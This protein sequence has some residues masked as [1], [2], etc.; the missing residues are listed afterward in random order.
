M[1]VISDALVRNVA[2]RGL[3]SKDFH[4][5]PFEIRI[6]NATARRA[7]DGVRA[8]D[9]LHV[10]VV[11]AP[12]VAA[13][14][15]RNEPVKLVLGDVCCEPHLLWGWYP[16]GSAHDSERFAGDTLSSAVWLPEEYLRGRRKLTLPAS[17][18]AA[19]LAARAIVAGTEVQ[20]TVEPTSS[21][22]TLELPGPAMD[23][24][25]VILRLVHDELRVPADLTANPHGDK[26]ALSA[27][28]SLLTLNP[29]AEPISGQ[30]ANDNN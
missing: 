4:I 12:L 2:L 5:W 6:T 19:P 7:P 28:Y 27:R 1:K 30:R 11:P 17:S 13:R 21:T 24:D 9:A 16:T 15:K 14:P 22:L 23:A 26:R 8:S 10:T 3:A 18:V 29:T 25:G 20:F